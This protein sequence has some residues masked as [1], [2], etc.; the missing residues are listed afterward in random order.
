MAGT[1]LS[2]LVIL[3]SYLAWDHYSTTMERANREL[4]RGLER[5]SPGHYEAAVLY[6][7]RAIA[8]DPQLVSAYL[9][10]GLARRH[11]G[12]WQEALSDFDRAT[13]LDDIHRGAERCAARMF[14][15]NVGVFSA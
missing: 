14:E 1:A 15:D 12:R 13:A 8:I 7:D 9:N 2:L 5:M 3:G 6:L 4:A 11:L 10:R